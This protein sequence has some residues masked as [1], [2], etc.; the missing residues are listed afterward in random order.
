MFQANDD[1]QT[2]QEIGKASNDKKLEFESMEFDTRA[3]IQGLGL[4]SSS[5]ISTVSILDFN[6]LP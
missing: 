4:S 3:C 5:A 6:L 1:I 2:I